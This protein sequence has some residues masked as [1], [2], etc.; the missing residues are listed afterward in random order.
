LDHAAAETAGNSDYDMVFVFRKKPDWKKRKISGILSTAGKWN[1]AW[2]LTANIIHR[3]KWKTAGHLFLNL[4]AKRENFMPLLT[5]FDGKATNCTNYT[6][7]VLCNSCRFVSFVAV[8]SNF[9][10]NDISKVP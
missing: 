1:T 6:N 8:L 10:S 4:S 9:L 3:K 2:L 7:Y 5:K